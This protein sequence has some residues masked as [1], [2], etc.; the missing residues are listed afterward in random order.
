M[1]LVL[2]E[3]KLKKYSIYE[4]RELKAAFVSEHLLYPSE[5]EELRTDLW[6]GEDPEGDLVA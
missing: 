1:Q 4:G 3:P 5:I 6:D 2:I